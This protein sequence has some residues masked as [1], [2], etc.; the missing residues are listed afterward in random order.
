MD[1]GGWRAWT[2]DDVSAWLESLGLAKYVEL[3]RANEIA[4]GKSLSDPCFGRQKGKETSCTD[5]GF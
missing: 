5:G 3:F 2:K 1:A 4:G